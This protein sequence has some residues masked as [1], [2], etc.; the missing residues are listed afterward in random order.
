MENRKMPEA[1]KIATDGTR[2]MADLNLNRREWYPIGT[3]A[4]FTGAAR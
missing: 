2:L 4:D 3:G 1:E